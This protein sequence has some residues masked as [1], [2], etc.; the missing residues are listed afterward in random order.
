[1]AASVEV[2]GLSKVLR[3]LKTLGLEVDDLK[4]AFQAI[5]I[6]AARR[7]AGYAPRKTGRLAGD[8]RG[9]RA[10]SKASVIAGRASIRYA[11]P[12]NYGWPRRNIAPSGFM[13]KASDEME[14]IA[15]R[16]LEADINRKIRSKG[17]N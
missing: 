7:A 11:G 5:A 1:M 14:P 4:D 17:L 13:Q 2:E 6:E 9:N 15:V 10:Q 12:I 16:L 8:I 3:D